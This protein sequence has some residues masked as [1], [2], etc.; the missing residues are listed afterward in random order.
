[1][2][3]F[4]GLLLLKDNLENHFHDGTSFNNYSIE[5]CNTYGVL[6]ICAPINLHL[7]FP[8]DIVFG[9]YMWGSM[10]LTTFSGG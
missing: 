10:K 8:Y 9:F 1:M 3:Y 7:I 5:H 4:M 2:F 6:Q